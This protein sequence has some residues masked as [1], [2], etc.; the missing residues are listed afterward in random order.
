[1]TQTK[2]QYESLHKWTLQP[3]AEHL[4]W[5]R[6]TGPRL[7]PETMS[8]IDSRVYYV[9]EDPNAPR[10]NQFLTTI[11]PRPQRKVGG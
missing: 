10:G 5:M 7:C 1:M 4:E 8:R 2:Q 3:K 11:D 6:K 9:G